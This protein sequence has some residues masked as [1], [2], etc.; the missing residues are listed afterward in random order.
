M[1]VQVTWPAT[2]KVK[3]YPGFTPKQVQD[4]T[5][6]VHKVSAETGVEIK[7]TILAS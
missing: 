3:E 6:Q 5:A 2:G 4:L 1:T 7:V